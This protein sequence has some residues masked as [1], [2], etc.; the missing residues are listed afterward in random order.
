MFFRRKP[1]RTPTFQ[2][3][4]ESLRG[5]G[6]RTDA[7]PDRRV[8]V[9]RDACAAI[10]EDALDGGA[11]I[12]RAGRLLGD[13]IA[14]LVD[15][16]YQKFWQTPDGCRVPALAHQL[17]ELHDFEEDLREALGLLSLYNTSLGTTNDLHLYDRLRS[18]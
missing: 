14:L 8:Q 11:R 9:S 3:R 6:F 13:E 5:S 15:V 18:T 1:P 17:E 12:H 2:E 16:G 4:L 10:I 7:R